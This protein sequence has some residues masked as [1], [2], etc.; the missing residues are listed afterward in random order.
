[1][2]PVTV[3]ILASDDGRRE[4]CRRLLQAAHLSVLEA[5]TLPSALEHI[6][7]ADIALVDWCTDNPDLFLDRW[8]AAHGDKPVMVVRDTSMSVNEGLLYG[9]GAWHVI[10]NPLQPGT[11]L[12]IMQRYR[13]HLDLVAVVEQLG[14]D[15]SRLRRLVVILSVGC[16]S[17]FAGEQV[18]PWLIRLVEGVV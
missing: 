1:M 11:L 6:P 4:H 10:S 17:L 16:A 12:N 14:A 8:V 13:Y 7:D 18:L 2:A 3:L 15:I 5:A 9:R